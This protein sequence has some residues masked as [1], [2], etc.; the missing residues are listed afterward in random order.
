MDA[1]KLSPDLTVMTTLG[2]IAQGKVLLD[3]Y[4][5]EV[6]R[7]EMTKDNLKIVIRK[8]RHISFYGSL[9]KFYLGNNYQNFG[10]S[11]CIKAVKKLT[12]FLG[13]HAS[14]VT[15]H[16]LEFG[17]NIHFDED[18]DL[19]DQALMHK[20]RPFEGSTMGSA[21]IKGKFQKKS[22][23]IIKLYDKGWQALGRM[24]SRIYRFEVKVKRMEKLSKHRVTLEDLTQERFHL[25]LAEKLLE[26]YDNIDWVEESL[27]N[28]I[29]N[30]HDYQILSDWYNP[31]YLSNLRREGTSSYNAARKRYRRRLEKYWSEDLLQVKLRKR[32]EEKIGHLIYGAAK[33]D[34][35]DVYFNPSHSSFP[36]SIIK[37]NECNE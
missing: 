10:L 16:N 21:E 6:L 27:L 1:A 28:S 33:T 3:Q 24:D 9:A 19:V 17:V 23:Y 20:G 37:T 31:R 35:L 30:R 2:A 5:G 36:S 11:D 13:C 29:T 7:R 8:E 25:L 32:I 22:Q 34:T 15:I 14:E 26:A 12:D 4:T 18:I